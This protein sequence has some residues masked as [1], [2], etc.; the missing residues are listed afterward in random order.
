MPNG[1]RVNFFEKER[2]SQ[3]AVK[4]LIKKLAGQAFR[5]RVPDARLRQS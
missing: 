2:G 5:D 4:M 1:V 3:R